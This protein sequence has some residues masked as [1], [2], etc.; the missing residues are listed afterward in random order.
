MLSP[1][2]PSRSFHAWFRAAV[3]FPFALVFALALVLLPAT[4]AFAAL[5]D[6]ATAVA[7]DEARLGARHVVRQ[8]GKYALHEFAVPTGTTI[9]EFVG[10]AGKV[11]AV[12]WSGGF[13]PNLRDVMGAHYDRFIAATRGRRATRG[14]ARIELPGMTVV[15]GGYLRTFWG[16]VILTD[17]LPPGVTPEELR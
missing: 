17:L 4:V 10:D 7:A 11:F 2:A 8:R 5:G 6:D 9:R 1:T 16:Q 14:I 12:S 15:M 3:G 13:R